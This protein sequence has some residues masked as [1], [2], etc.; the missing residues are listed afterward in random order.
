MNRTTANDGATARGGTQ[1]CK[2]HSYGHI[3][4]SAMIIAGRSLPPTPDDTFINA[5][6][7]LNFNAINRVLPALPKYS[8]K[9]S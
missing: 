1:F 6:H 7:C 4:L 9:F 8:A 3:T 2:G 5:K